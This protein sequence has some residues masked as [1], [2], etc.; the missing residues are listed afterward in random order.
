MLPA[1]YSLN[2]KLDIM[3]LVEQH[4]LPCCRQSF[5]LGLCCGERLSP[6]V[7]ARNSLKKPMLSYLQK[8]TGRSGSVRWKN[9]QID[10]KNTDQL[11][12]RQKFVERMARASPTSSVKHCQVAFLQGL[13]ISRGYIQ[14][15][16][17][18]YHLEYRLRGRW[19]L[20][21]F[22]KIT[23]CLK[24][25]FAQYRNGRD[26]CFYVKSGRRIVRLLNKLGLFEKSLELSDL[27]ATRSI[28]SMVNRQVNFE[29]A[30][31]NR[32]I[33]AAEESIRQIHDLL[34]YHDQEIWAESLR[35]LSLMR[36]KFPHDSLENLGKRFDPPLSK[37]AVNHRLRRVK[38]MHAR[39]FP[40]QH[41]KESFED[42]D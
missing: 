19:L 24:V 8:I 6:Y 16:S 37:S 17:R 35:Q 25:K 9:G 15:P 28:L 3:V 2:L 41:R 33:D 22:K 13:F 18:G 39:F 40:G 14:N 34:D 42:D 10:L 7:K 11:V 1:D 20:A 29:T 12:L 31:I 23:A 30:N 26:V 38:S 36:L 21:A 32:L 4:Q 5:L 27:T